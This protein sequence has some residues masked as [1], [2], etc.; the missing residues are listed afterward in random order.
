MCKNLAELTSKRQ[1]VIKSFQDNEGMAEYGSRMKIK[2]LLSHYAD[3]KQI[4]LSDQ[5]YKDL[6]SIAKFLAANQDEE[7]QEKLQEAC[8]FLYKEG[9]ELYCTRADNLY[10]GSV[11]GN[12]VGEELAK[13]YQMHC[14]S[15]EYINHYNKQEDFSVFLELVHKCKIKENLTLISCDAE[16]NP[17]FWSKLSSHDRRSKY[18]YKRDW[19]IDRLGKLLQQRSII[20]SK[21]IWDL[22]KNKYNSWEYF[23]AV[24]RPNQIANARQC[25]STLIFYLKNYPW[26]PDQYNQM[27]KPSE[28]TVEELRQDFNIDTSNPL[29]IALGLKS[30]AWKQKKKQQKKQI[31][32]KNLE[33]RAEDLGMRV[34]TK[35][36][37]ENFNR[38]LE[39]EKNRIKE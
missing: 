4:E 15:E 29:A 1:D 9:N 14:L 6:L 28:I 16:R 22:L 26:L 12:E 19:T 21:S 11:Y 39:E 8:I 25:D 33:R 24:Y 34:I 20:I 2:Q 30:I 18:I 23:I 10:L 35:E 17:E 5:Y 13:V 31:A 3:A 32:I 38:L 37:A 7:I 27:H 36:D